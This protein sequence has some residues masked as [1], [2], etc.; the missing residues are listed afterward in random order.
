[1]SQTAAEGET[2]VRAAIFYQI[3]CTSGSAGACN[4]LGVVVEESDQFNVSST[5]IVRL[6]QRACQL[7]SAN[8]CFNLGVAFRAGAGIERSAAEALKYFR[9]ACDHGMARGCQYI[10][11]PGETENSDGETFE[12]AL[13]TVMLLENACEDGAARACTRAGIF[14]REGHGGLNRD[15]SAAIEWFKRGC[16]EGDPGG[17]SQYAYHLQEG[18]GV[19]RDVSAAA[20]QF[21]VACEGGAAS[22]CTYL[23][24]LYAGGEVDVSEPHRRAAELFKM[25]C[26][27]DDLRACVRLGRMLQGGWQVSI[28]TP[29]AQELFEQACDGGHASACDELDALGAEQNSSSGKSG[30]GDPQD[31]HLTTDRPPGASEK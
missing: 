27:E 12:K 7:G 19:D 30:E 24:A 18:L 22:A 5:Q 11:V 28:E 17:C 23:G 1:V 13:R 14:H 16:K 25:A 10:G 26:E 21:A 20:K 4:A 15:Q 9:R 6:Y 3:G 29:S 2:L 31:E 8:G